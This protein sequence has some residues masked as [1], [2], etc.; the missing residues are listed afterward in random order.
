MQLFEAYPFSATKD[1]LVIFNKQN[2]W[3]IFEKISGQ[4]KYDIFENVGIFLIDF[5]AN[6][7]FDFRK[8][9][10]FSRKNGRS[11]KSWQQIQKIV[12][13]CRFL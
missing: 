10:I 3:N 11:F 6:K 9:L 5:E 12:S 2:F 13:V 7:M 8:I 4:Q 1:I